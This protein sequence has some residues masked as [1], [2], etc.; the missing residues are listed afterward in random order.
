MNKNK[1]IAHESVKPENKTNLLCFIFDG[2]SASYFSPWKYKIFDDIN[3]IPILYPTRE[4]R[5]NDSMYANM[6][7]FVKDLVESLADIFRG[8][9]SF[10]G[11]CS[12][13][14]IAYE[15]AVLAKKVYGTEPEYGMI[16]SSEAPKY[17]CESVPIITDENREKLFFDHMSGLPMVDEKTLKDKVFLDYYKPLFTADYGLLNTYSY[18]KRE[19]LSCDFD[20]IMCPD[21]PKVERERVE[22]WRELTTGK[23]NIIKKDG[24]HFLVDT[25]VEYILATLNG[26]LSKKTEFDTNVFE[27]ASKYKNIDFKAT[28]TEKIIIQIWKEIF[29]RDDF[30][31]S[32]NFFLKGGDSL[33]AVKIVNAIKKEFR[34]D[35]N[36][37]D[38]FNNLE[39]FKFAKYVSDLATKKADETDNDTDE[40]EI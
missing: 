17:L 26:R 21:D 4:K 27:E 24:G 10:F 3:L 15:A 39:I 34:I 18:E 22:A 31:P 35:V 29:K 19:E 28:D 11:Y 12:G 38:I 40:G 23:T 25:Q 33:K 36:I 13:S 32:D 1:W 37:K 8:R 7:A 30:Y 16:V 5:R 6:N 9:Y 20:V 2:G 14:I